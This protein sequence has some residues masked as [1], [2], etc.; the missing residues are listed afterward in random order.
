M[1][2]ILIDYLTNATWQIAVL[3][4]GAWLF[5]R[6]GKFGPRAQHCIWLAVL[7]LAVGLPLYGVRPAPPSVTPTTCT[8]CGIDAIPTHGREELP[9]AALFA[10]F[11]VA[12]PR[13]SKEFFTLPRPTVRLS[14]V[15]TNWVI[16]MYFAVLLFGLYRILTSLRRARQLVLEADP[17]VLPPRWNSTFQ[18]SGRQL[19]TRLPQLRTSADVRSPVIVGVM[20]PVLLL[21]KDFESHSQ[22]EVQ[23]ALFH[24]LAHVRRHD[25]LGNLLC[26]LAALPVAWHPL[27]YGVQQRIRRTREMV[28]DDIAA[29]AM[30]SEI[31]YAK[32]LIAMAGRTLREH[33]LADAAQAIGLFGD[34]V[35]EERIMRLMQEKSTPTMQTKLAR[36][37]IGAIAMIIATVMAASFHVTP[38]LAQTSGTAVT[39]PAPPAPPLRP[40]RIWQLRRQRPHR[41]I[42]LGLLHRFRQCRRCPTPRRRLLLRVPRSHRLH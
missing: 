18:D 22:N 40:H 4:G 27:T 7:A 41:L 21:P 20:H 14:R 35:L 11:L 24:E 13:F 30:Q 19:G 23:A 25:Y 9:R 15:E 38:T 31:G 1:E 17:A 28:C 16:G 3:A 42:P 5:I 36:I 29:R 32:C 6:V 8:H 12:V 33:D 34:N 2:Q 39:V 10:Q 26:Q 37:T